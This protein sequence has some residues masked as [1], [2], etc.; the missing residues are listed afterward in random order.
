L[1]QQVICKI[2]RRR[3]GCRRASGGHLSRLGFWLQSLLTILVVLMAGAGQSL[4][5]SPVVTGIRIEG[6]DTR[7]RIVAEVTAE[8]GFIVSAVGEPYR[9]TLDIP[10]VRFDLPTGTGRKKKGLVRQ[11]RYGT[12]AAGKPQIVLDTTGPVLIE[13]SFATGTAGKRKARIVVELVA[14]TPEV[15]AAAFARDNPVATGASTSE[16]GETTASLPLL[17]P[18][19][20]APAKPN[21]QKRVIVIDPGHGGIDPG[22][23]SARRTKEKDVVFD[24]AKAL[25]QALDMSGHYDV[26]LTRDGDTF[27][28]L[29]D[30]VSVAREAKADLFIAIHADTVRGQT[31]TGT[32]LYTL[33]ETASDAEAEALA[34]KE[35]KVDDIAGINLGQQNAEVADILIDLVRRESKNHAML[36][37]RAALDE[38]KGVTTM[39]GKPLRSAGF[40]VLKAPDVPSV[41]IELG[42]LSSLEDEEKLLSP[43]WR[44]RMAKALA[45]AVDRHFAAAVAVASP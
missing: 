19:V 30:R 5:E 13:K 8:T 25:K 20:A 35:N 37:S 40:M 21:G 43:A 26:R 18:G 28:T 29:R 15:F 42:Y 14:T 41:L 7:T 6:S 4:A 16:T 32:T 33:S 36:F 11:L 2:R 22:A 23:V 45:T 24:F 39:T 27:I 38:I 44:K 34:Q 1:F 31:V 9:I 10:D 3:A 12:S 17:M